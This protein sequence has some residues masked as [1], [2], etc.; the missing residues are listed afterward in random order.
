MPND[1][2][3]TNANLK[4]QQ[5]KGIYGIRYTGHNAMFQMFLWYFFSVVHVQWNRIENYPSVVLKE[6][7]VSHDG[8]FLSTFS[9]CWM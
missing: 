4:G 3:V 6:V 5:I 1:V 9:E 7:W 2:K 8:L